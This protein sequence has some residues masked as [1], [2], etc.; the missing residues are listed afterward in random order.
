MVFLR[1]RSSK[2]TILEMVGTVPEIFEEVRVS[3]LR[4]VSALMVDGMVPD[5]PLYEKSSPVSLARYPTADGKVPLMRLKVRE[6]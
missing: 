3:V 1:F 5:I 6:R 2:A 4:L